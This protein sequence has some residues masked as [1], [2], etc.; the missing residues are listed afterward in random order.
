MARRYVIWVREDAPGVEAVDVWLLRDRLRAAGVVV[1]GGA[2]PFRLDYELETVAG[3]R[4]RRL[5]AVARGEGWRR[6]LLLER[7]ARGAWS[8]QVEARGRA[9]LPAAGGSPAALAGATDCD[10][11]GSA[12]TNSMP[13][14]RHGLLAAPGAADLLVA[15][16]DVP[17]LS[18]LA[19]RQRYRHLGVDGGAAHVRYLSPGSGFTA[20]LAFDRDG[21]VRDYPG[22]AR[23]A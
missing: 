15:F 12:L 23:R 13:V 4:T 17:S 1:A 3:W 18:V 14:L 16:V 2:V 7:G 19:V 5:H 22:L 21:L 6:E 11:G 10:L 9:R 8:V 20:D